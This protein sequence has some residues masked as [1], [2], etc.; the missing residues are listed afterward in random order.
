MAAVL[1]VGAAVEFGPPV[2][3]TR[4]VA[5]ATVMAP[6]FEVDLTWPK[7]LPNRWILGQSIGVSADSHDHIWMIHRPGSL[8]AGEQHAAINPPIAQCCIPAPP[9]LK[10]NQDGDLVG[11]RG[12]PGRVT[13]GP[14]PTT[15][16]PWIPRATCGLAATAGEQRANAAPRTGRTKRPAGGQLSRQHDSEVH[17]RRR[18]SH[19]RSVSRR[20][21][22]T[23]RTC[24]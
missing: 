14:F 15:E 3:K 9:I 2:G 11:H 8:E 5:A 19:C 7:P 23:S 24:A 13:T 6:R 4:T 16:S 21:A 12:G 22:K 20:A 17:A 10:F 18:I 1:A